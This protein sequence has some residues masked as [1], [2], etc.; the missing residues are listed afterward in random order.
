MCAV[1]TVMF[2]T[3]SAEGVGVVG[4]RFL[5]WITVYNKIPSLYDLIR[6]LRMMPYEGKRLWDGELSPIYRRV[7]SPAWHYSWIKESI[8]ECSCCRV[9]NYSAWKARTNN[10]LTPEEKPTTGLSANTGNQPKQQTM[11]GNNEDEH[12]QGTACNSTILCFILY[13]LHSY[14]CHTEWW[15]KMKRRKKW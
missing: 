12:T 13:S 14:G 15:I 6:A 11:R 2:V 9:L 3:K 8:S 4:V 5:L 1:T 10:S 7:C